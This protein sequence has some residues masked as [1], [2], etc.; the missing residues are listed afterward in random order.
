MEVG[1]ILGIKSL[2]VLAVPGTEIKVPTSFPYV[3][4]FAP[5]A[6]PLELREMNGVSFYRSPSFTDFYVDVVFKGDLTLKPGFLKAPAEVVGVVGNEVP[7]CGCN[8]VVNLF[9]LERYTSQ[10]DR[11]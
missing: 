3:Y 10:T 7:I 4:I 5:E 11:P 8:V 9:H 2:F 1:E 6:V